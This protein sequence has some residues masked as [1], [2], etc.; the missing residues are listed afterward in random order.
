M[1]M[2]VHMDR[3]RV[4]VLAL[5]AA[6][7][8]SCRARDERVRVACVGDSI[9]FSTGVEDRGR[10]SYPSALQRL[11]SNSYHVQNFGVNGATVGRESDQPYVRESAFQQA[12]D[13]QPNVVVI[14]LGANDTKL[15]NWAHIETFVTDYRALIAEFAELGSRPRI[16]LCVP[17]PAFA[18]G[19]SVNRQRL[20]E[21]RPKIERLGTDLNLPVIDLYT[22]LSA[23]PD[24]FPDG[25]HPNA[26]G[27]G[28]IADLVHRSL[29]ATQQ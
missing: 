24:L 28:R 26:E 1:A 29:T 2:A 23:R 10:D 6:L 4:V 16:Y 19:E 22:E 20:R 7:G 17:V 9:T 15:Q 3:R 21:L 11:L 8:T 14:L 18:D 13:F 5:F 12:K 25:V 27:A